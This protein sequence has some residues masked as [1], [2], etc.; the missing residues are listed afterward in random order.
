MGVG[1]LIAEC[2][3][4]LVLCARGTVYTDSIYSL[5]C[6]SQHILLAGALQATS[7]G[8][9]SLQG[10]STP[11]P[12]EMLFRLSGR[13]LASLGPRN[14]SLISD[15]LAFAARPCGPPLGA[16]SDS[17]ASC[18]TSG[19]RV[20]AGPDGPDSGSSG[21]PGSGSVPAVGHAPPPEPGAS[22]SGPSASASLTAE[23]A[24]SGP[25]LGAAGRSP[26]GQGT[27]GSSGKS[28]LGERHGAH[29]RQRR[30]PNPFAV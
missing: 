11:N 24:S 5:T 19:R 13:S 6:R 2:K 8:S 18:G 4:L 22:T 17:T 7:T 3:L 10:A 14:S 30:G 23:G 26:P 15:D 9:G 20:R 27:P 25:D 16:R 12:G 29:V 28:A 21:G 1:Q